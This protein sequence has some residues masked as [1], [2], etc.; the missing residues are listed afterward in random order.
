MV[1]GKLTIQNA[2]KTVGISN[3]CCEFAQKLGAKETHTIYNS[4]DTEFWRKEE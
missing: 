3:K 1:F 2:T 4:V